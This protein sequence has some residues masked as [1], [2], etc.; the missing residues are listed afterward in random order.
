[1]NQ[2]ND[3]MLKHAYLDLRRDIVLKQSTN[4]RM[5]K[6]AK[7]AN[8]MPMMHP[9]AKNMRKFFI[10]ISCRFVLLFHFKIVCAAKTSRRQCWK[11]GEAKST[12]ARAIWKWNYPAMMLQLL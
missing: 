5:R 7:K 2:G 9:I 12:K 6:A 11:H 10:S 1:M 4:G 3:L 8:G